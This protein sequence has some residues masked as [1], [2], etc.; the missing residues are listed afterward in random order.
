MTAV[1]KGPLIEAY[2]FFVGLGNLR[3]MIFLF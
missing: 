3:I 2:S 1:L